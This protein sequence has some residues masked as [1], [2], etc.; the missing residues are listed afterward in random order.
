LEQPS[1]ISFG[2][3]LAGTYVVFD[4]DRNQVVAEITKA[5]GAKR[6][7][8]LPPGNYYIKK[9]LP[10]AVLLQK[11]SLSRGGKH[12]VRDH[13]MR[14]VPYEEDVT[15][16]RSS[17]VFYPTWKYGA[18]FTTNTAHTLR[19]GELS[20]GIMSVDVGVGDAVM[21]S[22]KTI[23]D[24]FLIPNAL[25]K[26]RLLH[27]DHVVWSMH[28]EFYISFLEEVVERRSD[29]HPF[30][31]EVG[32]T[33]SWLAASWMTISLLGN[34]TIGST[35][36][37]WFQSE[38]SPEQPEMVGG[39]IQDVRGGLSITWLLGERNLIQVM[40]EVVYPF[41]SPRYPEE[42]GAVDWNGTVLYGIQWK[43]FR[44]LIGVTRS[45]WITERMPLQFGILPF[46]DLR[47]RW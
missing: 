23:W 33:L 40:G 35:P 16:G 6:R 34:W 46:T 4:R 17:E 28:T 36:Y 39:E 11:V 30:G 15:K 2:E 10:T 18:P 22:T 9:R 47:W 26:L 44:L 13:E 32:S 1:Y 38:E 5:P 21:L 29:R 37:S 14:T 19:R 12:D 43:K 31:F 27:G 20:L 25:V 3:D 41:Y 24:F 42:V 45:S 8:W 7:L